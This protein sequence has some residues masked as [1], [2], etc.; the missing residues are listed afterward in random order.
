VLPHIFEPYFTTKEDKGTGLGLAIVSR[1]V[2]DHH[3]LLHVE[4]TVGEGT[5]ITVYFPAKEPSP[6]NDPFRM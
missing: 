6:S 5:R 1:L 2:K 3:G 4:T